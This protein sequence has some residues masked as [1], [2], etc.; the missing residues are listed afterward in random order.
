[1]KL[2]LTATSSDS[3]SGVLERSTTEEC[4]ERTVDV[5]LYPSQL[6]EVR[7][8]VLT[9]LKHEVI[10]GAYQNAYQKVCKCPK[11]WG[12]IDFTNFGK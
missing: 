12:E 3:H 6:V 5:S 8:A 2:P 4:M 1:M 11:K 7:A 10:Y 9:D